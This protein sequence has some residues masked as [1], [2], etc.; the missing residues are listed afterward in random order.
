MAEKSALN[1]SKVI[2]GWDKQKA[3]D[4]LNGYKA[5]TYGGAMKGMMQGQVKVLSDAEI[6][7]LAEFISKQ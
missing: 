2:A 4:A 1:T 7:A 3:L 5:G 6:D